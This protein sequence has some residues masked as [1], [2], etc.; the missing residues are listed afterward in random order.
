MPELH[1]DYHPPHIDR[2]RRF[3]SLAGLEITDSQDRIEAFKQI[4]PERFLDLLSVANGLVRDI[5]TFQR[6]DGKVKGAIVAFRGMDPEMQPPDNA[7]EQFLDIFKT[8][9]SEIVDEQDSIDKASVQLYF[10]I[11]GS[12]L[13][14]DGNGRTARAAF[15]LLRNGRLPNDEQVLDRNAAKTGKICDQLNTRV[16]VDM[17][18][19]SGLP[20]E[21]V[22]NRDFVAA[23]TSDDFIATYGMTQHL[24]YLAARNLKIAENPTN[25]GTIPPEKITLSEETDFVRTNFAS[26]YQKIRIEWLKKFIE[27]P[28]QYV[29]ICINAIEPSLNL[30]KTAV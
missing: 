22:L 21:M 16:V 14:S 17:M 19:E 11:I 25:Q 4:E 3:D 20:R 7:D 9:Q 26:E 18:I 2:L 13:F 30:Q 8:L 28:G 27:T 23:E 24:K 12:H 29:D 6:W 5:D 15:H 1:P 10:A